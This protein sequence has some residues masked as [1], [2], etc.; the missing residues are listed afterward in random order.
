M[1]HHH[2][3]LPSVEPKQF[4]AELR[5]ISGRSVGWRTIAFWLVR[6]RELEIEFE[7]VPTGERT[8]EILQRY[9][10]ATLRVSLAQL[11][12]LYRGASGARAPPRPLL[13]LLAAL[14]DLKDGFNSRLL[15]T[16]DLAEQLPKGRYSSGWHRRIRARSA[17]LVEFMLRNGIEQAQVKA[18]ARVASSLNKSGY[19]PQG[20][21]KLGQRTRADTVK[22]WHNAAR[23]GHHAL[24]KQFHFELQVLTARARIPPADPVLEAT[25]GLVSLEQ[26][27]EKYH[28]INE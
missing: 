2:H 13:H 14:E 15:V 16:G 10:A 18:A 17:A 26:V 25:S 20:K 3:P 22:R 11:D 7:S 8:P 27:C 4:E 24:S 23:F 28:I 19:A 21:I 1:P 12:G 6:L 9:A 5:R